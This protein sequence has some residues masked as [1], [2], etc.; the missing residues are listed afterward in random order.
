MLVP[1]G[2]RTSRL[3]L[4]SHVGIGSR[5]HDFGGD[6]HIILLIYLTVIGLNDS[7][8]CAD[9]SWWRGKPVLLLRGESDALTFLSSL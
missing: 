2:T 1:I 4:N 3:N 9:D 7:M 5:E 6:P 8:V